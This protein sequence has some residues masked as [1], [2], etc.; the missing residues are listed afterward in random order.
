MKTLLPIL[1]TK[2]FLLSFISACTVILATTIPQVRN[3]ITPEKKIGEKITAEQKKITPKINKHSKTVSSSRVTSRVSLG[4]NNSFDAG[5][6]GY[7]NGPHVTVY[8]C[9]PC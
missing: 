3:F 5:T 7:F 9:K 1:K 6:I 8:N 4:M 2:L